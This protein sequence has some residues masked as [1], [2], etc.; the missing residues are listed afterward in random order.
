M[1]VVVD[2]LLAAL[3]VGLIGSAGCVRVVRQFERGVVFLFGRVL[4]V[5]RGPGLALLVPIGRA[6][7]R[8]SGSAERAS[9]PR[10][11]SCRLERSTPALKTAGSAQPERGGLPAGCA[12]PAWQP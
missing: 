11:G 1:V 3:V 10:M 12:D 9:S 8:P 5:V 2:V 6:R 4:P 7:Q